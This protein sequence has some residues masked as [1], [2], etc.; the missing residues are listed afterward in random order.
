LIKKEEL[1]ERNHSG[2]NRNEKPP[3]VHERLNETKM[4][5]IPEFKYYNWSKNLRKNN[6][7]SPNPGY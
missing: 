4:E 3:P 2:P 1:E 6:S 5:S 7:K